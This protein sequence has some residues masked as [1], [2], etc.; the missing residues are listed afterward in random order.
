[1]ST[2]G[3]RDRSPSDTIT[4]RHA[5][6]ETPPRPGRVSGMPVQI[7]CETPSCSTPAAASILDESNYRSPASTGICPTPL[8]TLQAFNNPVQFANDSRLREEELLLYSLMT[9]VFLH[10]TFTKN[11]SPNKYHEICD[12]IFHITGVNFST[13][14]IRNYFHRVRTNATKGIG[15]TNGI[16]RWKY[17]KK[18]VVSFTEENMQVLEKALHSEADD[19]TIYGILQ[20]LRFYCTATRLVFSGNG[21]IWDYKFDFNSANCNFDLDITPHLSNAW[22]KYFS[23]DKNMLHFYLFGQCPG[24]AEREVVVTSAIGSCTLKGNTG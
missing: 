8:D 12:T 18:H 6:F 9:L 7:N 4:K 11:F 22:S 17:F 3:K 23:A 15:K 16:L 1:M 5:S 14:S 13:Q 20:Q 10:N 21:Q 2:V 19:A 24:Y